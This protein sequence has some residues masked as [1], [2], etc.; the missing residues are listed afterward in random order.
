MSVDK[1]GRHLSGVKVQRTLRESLPYRLTDGGNIDVENKII[2]NVSEPVASTDAVTLSYMQKHCLPISI[3]NPVNAKD[4]VNKVYLDERCLQY[5]NNVIDARNHR[6]TNVAEPQEATDAANMR[7]V[8]K[9]SINFVKGAWWFN[10]FPLTQVGLPLFGND[11]VNLNFMRENSIT[12]QDGI[13]N[14]GGKKIVNVTSGSGENDVVNVQQ[15][16]VLKRHTESELYKINN[17]VR[18]HLDRI[19]NK[20]HQS[21]PRTSEGDEK[22]VWTDTPTLIEKHDKSTEV[23]DWRSVYE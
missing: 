7:Y 3:E 4:A 16:N 10:N 8:D 22:S 17:V 6:V 23:K 15:L 1:F 14:A 12:L 9:K 11:A 19:Y 20:L 13:F 21:R 18:F 5:N 2:H